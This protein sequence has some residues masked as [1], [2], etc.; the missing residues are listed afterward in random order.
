[1]IGDGLRRTDRL[2][3]TATVVLVALVGLGVL[4]RMFQ[5]GGDPTQFVGPRQSG[6]TG[7]WLFGTDSLGRSVLARTIDGI[8]TT[9][10]L[11]GTAVVLAALV[12]TLLGGLA[13]LRGGVTDQLL[14]RFADVLLSFPTILLAI[15]VAAIVGPGLTAPVIA[16]LI[17]TVPLLYRVVRSA[18]VELVGRDFV[19]NARISGAGTA[20]LLLVHVVPN[21]AGAAVVQA[22]YALSMGILIESALSFLGLGVR[23]P[24]ASLGSLLQE[25]SLYLPV[26]PWPT[27]GP[28]IVLALAV[29]SVNLC[30]D[31]LRDAFEPRDARALT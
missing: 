13:A 25:N 28:G 26:N 20:R 29:L 9:I 31:G 8:G 15:V 16:I 19:L 6:P 23:E 10:V 18:A 5:L 7:A 12:G 14:T 3:L 30:G 21:V 17:A 2:T 4:G 27:I 1:M 22:T 24:A 11:A